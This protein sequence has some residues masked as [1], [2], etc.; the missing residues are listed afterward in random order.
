MRIRK[1]SEHRYANCGYYVDSVFTGKMGYISEE[2]MLSYDTKVIIIRGDR[3]IYTGKY[4]VTTSKQQTWWLKEFGELVK[5]INKKTLE[6]MYN[7]HMAYDRK[8]GELMPLTKEEEREI[9]EI[10]H[11]A[12]RY[13]YGW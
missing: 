13:G 2:G 4:S 12:F 8:T 5:G 10:R 6:L 3:V 1:L 9:A 7:Q 11:A